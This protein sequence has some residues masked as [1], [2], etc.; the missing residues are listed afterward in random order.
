MSHQPQTKGA[1]LV[2]M[3]KNI[4]AYANEHHINHR[5]VGGVSY[6]GMLLEN[7][8]YDIDLANKTIHLHNHAPLEVLRG[9]RSVRDIDLIILTQDAKKIAA[10]RSH[11]E[12]LK[13]DTRLRMGFTPPVSYEG[14]F[15]LKTNAGGLLQYVTTIHTDGTNP[16]LVF[17]KIQRK[18]SWKSLEP[19]TLVLENGLC[20]TTRNPIADFYAYQ[21]R[22]PAGIKPKDVQKIIRLQ[23]LVEQMQKMGRK[24]HINYDGSSYYGPWQKYIEELESSP[25]SS[26]QTKRALTRWYWATLGTTLA[27]G[28]GII[29]KPIF[30]LFNLLNRIKQSS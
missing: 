9:D 26:V 11:L 17:D 27:H 8:N 24:H 13:W 3:I 2:D 14:L 18:I 25:L 22:S 16:Y 6:G 5:F 19:W 12:S 10:F 20:Y 23:K 7:T 29:G 28:R 1:L 21:F 15:D 30:A 4:E